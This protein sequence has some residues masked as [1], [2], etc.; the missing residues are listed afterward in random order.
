MFTPKPCPKCG[1]PMIK[2]RATRGINKGGYFFG[3]TNYPNCRGI[4]GIIGGPPP[5]IR[6]NGPQKVELDEA[7]RARLFAVLPD[8][9]QRDAN[10]MKMR[11]GIGCKAHTMEEIGQAL[12][13]SRERIRQLI[14]KAL[15]RSII[16]RGRNIWKINKE[17]HF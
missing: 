2:K 17:L 11:Y 5:K 8:L 13:L 7:T 10:I 6:L 9:S 1:S 12:G 3:C 4:I 14:K 16:R 15:R